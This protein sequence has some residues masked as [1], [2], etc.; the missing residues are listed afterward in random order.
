MPNSEGGLYLRVYLRV[1]LSGCK[2]PYIYL[3]V[4]LSGC[5]PPYIPQGVYMVGTASLGVYMVGTVSLGGYIPEYTSLGGIYQ[6]I[7]PWV[8]TVVYMPP[9]GV[10]SGV[11]ASLRCV[12]WWVSSLGERELCAK[13]SPPKGK[14]KNDAQRAPPMVYPRVRVNVVVPALLPSPSF[15][16]SLLVSSDGPCTTVLSVAGF[17][18]IPACFPFHCW[19]LFS[20][21]SPFH[22]W[23]FL[24]HGCHC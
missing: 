22:C 13:R 8:C 19:T 18:S 15:S 5:K 9:Y 23:T 17:P 21:I 7:P 10:Y 1:Y 20:D 24:D 2:P 4:Y 12:P 6:S 16:V 11:H 3:R 14:G